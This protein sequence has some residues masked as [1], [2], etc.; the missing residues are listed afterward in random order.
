MNDEIYRPPVVVTTKR[1]VY[2]TAASIDREQLF[3]RNVTEISN[4]IVRRINKKMFPCDIVFCEGK[5]VLAFVEF[6]RRIGV[7]GYN[8]GVMLSLHKATQLAQFG[9]L[10][11]KPTLFAIEHADNSYYVATL[12]FCGYAVEYGG[13]T[14]RGD[15]GDMEPVILIPIIDFKP[16]VNFLAEFKRDG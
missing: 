3:C 14:D 13:R 11:G 8:S 1:P 12:N 16:L 6:K 15:A 4:L 9:M 5:K 7:L 10:T 2:E